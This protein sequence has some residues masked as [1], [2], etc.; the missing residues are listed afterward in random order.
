ME[1]ELRWKEA[2][3]ARAALKKELHLSEAERLTLQDK[4]SDG[5]GDYHDVIK[6]RDC[7]AHQ[8]Q[9]WI[10]EA[11]SCFVQGF[12]RAKAQVELTVA[13]AD[14]SQLDPTKVVKNGALVDESDD[15]EGQP[16]NG[17]QVADSPVE[18]GPVL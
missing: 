17:E 16:A 12:E 5:G 8:V 18:T 1:S 6:E 10:K 13:G 2:V 7:L 14:L 4:L 11:G 3:R 15:E 9:A